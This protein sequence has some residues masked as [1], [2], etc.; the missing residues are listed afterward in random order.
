MR[1]QLKSIFDTM[2][3]NLKRILYARAIQRLNKDNWLWS[4]VVRSIDVVYFRMTD[5]TELCR[6]IGADLRNNLGK[7]QLYQVSLIDFDST[8]G[9]P[10]DHL[11][12]NEMSPIETLINLRA[13]AACCRVNV[14]ELLEDVY[15]HTIELKQQLKQQFVNV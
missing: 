6:E 7:L 4:Y 2:D 10:I 8:S 1:N 11:E 14:S 15:K 12:L 5:S 9:N 13:S 3:N